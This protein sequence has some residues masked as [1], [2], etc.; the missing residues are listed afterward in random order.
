MSKQIHVGFLLLF[1]GGFAMTWTNVLAM[2]VWTGASAVLLF[3]I[4]WV[5]SIFTKYNDLKEIK[6][7]NTAVTTRFVMKLFAQGYILSQSITKANDLWQALLASAVSFVILLVVEMFIEF[8]LKKMAGL[9]LEEG[10]KEGGVA[11]AMLAGSLHIVGALILG[12]CL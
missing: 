12:A 5:D 10:T 1:R 7:E 6:N 3:A 4:M 11:H 9:D 2:L 8:V